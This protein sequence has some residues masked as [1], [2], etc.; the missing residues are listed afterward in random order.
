MLSDTKDSARSR[1]KVVLRTFLLVGTC[2][3]GACDLTTAPSPPTTI[4]VG[5]AG[6]VPK[7]IRVKRF[8]HV[9]F[10]NNDTRAHSMLS[11]PINEHTQCPS[12]NRVGFLQP[13]ESRETYSLDLTG[14]CDFHDH[15]NQ[16]DATLKGRIVIE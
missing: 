14:I 3:T 8:A 10:V 4:S 15:L 6:V 13:G 5:A 16:S 7:E 9:M 11:D 2:V 1:R 12:L